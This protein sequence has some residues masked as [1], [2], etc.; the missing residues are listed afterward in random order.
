MNRP[1]EALCDESGLIGRTGRQYFEACPLENQLHHLEDRRVVFYNKDGFPDLSCRLSHH[2]HPKA[3]K[4]RSL[5]LREGCP[6]GWR[7][8][9]SGRLR[10]LDV[11][12]NYNLKLRLRLCSIAH[13]TGLTNPW[14]ESKMRDVGAFLPTTNAAA[15][16]RRTCWTARD[17]R[18]RKAQA[19]PA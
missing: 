8:N 6:A 16:G 5:G 11:Q 2:I 4:S 9:V 1:G 3:G 17:R 7:D 14:S 13:Y 15:W 19:Q 18:K 10:V 12:C